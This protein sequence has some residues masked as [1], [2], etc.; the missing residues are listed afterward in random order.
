MDM[1]TR[2]VG[3]HVLFE[4]N[5]WQAAFEI[6][7]AVSRMVPMVV[8]ITTGYVYILVEVTLFCSLVQNISP[9][10]ILLCI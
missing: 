1:H 6:E 3:D 5:E 2:R 8:G 10:P 4:S 7:Y 9:P